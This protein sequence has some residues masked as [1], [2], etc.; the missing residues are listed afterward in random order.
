MIE[1]SKQLHKDAYIDV[2]QSHVDRMIKD[3]PNKSIKDVK[4]TYRNGQK[5]VDK[6]FNSESQYYRSLIYKEKER[7]WTRMYTVY[8]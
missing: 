3:F 4:Y 2:L 8:M 6:F 1:R 7:Q 5:F